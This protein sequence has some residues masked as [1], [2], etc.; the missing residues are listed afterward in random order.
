MSQPRPLFVY[1]HPFLITISII[2]IEESVNGVL[3][4]QTWDRMM[5]GTYETTELRRPLILMRC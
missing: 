2:Q 4:I 1:F 3:G 5:V